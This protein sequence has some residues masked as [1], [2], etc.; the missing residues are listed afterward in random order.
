MISSI[1]TIHFSQ[2]FIKQVPQQDPGGVDGANDKKSKT[3]SPFEGVEGERPDDNKDVIQS[4]GILQNG[5]EEE[6][7]YG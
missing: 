4:N 3:P 2:Y 7:K 1:F 6:V 5:L